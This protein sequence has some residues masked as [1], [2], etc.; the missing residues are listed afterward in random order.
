MKEILDLNNGWHEAVIMVSELD[1]IAKDLE[2]VG[3][4]QVI[5]E[6]AVNRGQLNLWDLTND[7]TGDYKLI[8]NPNSHKGYVRLVKLHNQKQKQIRPA[9]QIWEAGGIFD[10]NFRVTNIDEKFEKLLNRGWTAF[11]QPAQYEFGPVI[12]SEV[13]MIGPDGVCFALIERLEPPL[14]EVESPNEISRSFNSSLL[15]ADIEK[16][17]KFFSETLGFET[18]M[19]LIG[20]KLDTGSNVLGLP[21]NIAQEHAMDV[22]IIHPKAVTD[23]SVELMSLNSL[24]G[25]N[26]SKNAKPFNLGITSLRFPINDVNKKATELTSKGIPLVYGPTTIELAPYGDVIIFALELPEG[27]WIEFFEPLNNI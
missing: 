4:W 7:V 21:H 6:G 24:K 17:F 11:N 10:L 23:G 8:R 5:E 25:R 26:F 20:H 27:G 14:E 9:G 16:S 22:C 13:L 2:I 19:E 18:V 1:R 3:N 12:V 15:V